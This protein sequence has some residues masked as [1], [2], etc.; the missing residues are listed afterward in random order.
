MPGAQ[1]WSYSLISLLQS[2]WAGLVQAWVPGWGQS[3]YYCPLLKSAADTFV[4]YFFISVMTCLAH[5]ACFTGFAMTPGC[6]SHFSLSLAI[7]PLENSQLF[8]LP[9]PIQEF[10]GTSRSP[11]YPTMQLKKASLSGWQSTPRLCHQ[12]IEYMGPQTQQSP[13]RLSK[14]EGDQSPCF[15]FI[16][17]HMT[18]FSCWPSLE[19]WSR[20]RQ[21]N[22]CYRPT[23]HSTYRL[24]TS[25]L[26]KGHRTVMSSF[27]KYHS[28]C[29]LLWDHKGEWGAGRETSLLIGQAPKQSFFVLYVKHLA[30]CLAWN[31]Y[32]VSGSFTNNLFKG[33]HL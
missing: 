24:L 6:D 25:F 19:L 4:I 20:E 7:L 16:S 22:I 18:P 14:R 15:K 10:V 9:P 11:A 26:W 30:L 27:W 13:P 28:T 8:S 31:M 23:M 5:W 29:S 33:R 12:S 1:L 21:Q 3:F 17:F 2:G 32:S